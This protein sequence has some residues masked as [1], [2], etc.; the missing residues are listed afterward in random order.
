LSSSSYIP[1]SAV[2]PL[3]ET[4]LPNTS[5]AAPSL[6]KSFGSAPEIERRKMAGMRDFIARV[7]FQV[8][9]DIVWDVLQ[10]KLGPL[11]QGVERLLDDDRQLIG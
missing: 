11:A 2:L 5:N 6:A 1:T 8:D 3:R 9:L 4:E 10:T 7:Y